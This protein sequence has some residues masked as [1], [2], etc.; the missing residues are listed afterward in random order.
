VQTKLVEALDEQKKGKSNVLS[1]AEL[2]TYVAEYG[3]KVRSKSCVASRR[4]SNT[5]SFLRV[6]VHARVCLCAASRLWAS[7][8]KKC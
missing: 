5:F 6:Y 7:F 2:Q 1:A 8:L 3:I 4:V